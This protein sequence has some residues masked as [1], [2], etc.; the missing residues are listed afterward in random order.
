[1]FYPNRNKYGNRKTVIDGITFDSAKEARR[2]SELK[3]MQRAGLISDLKLQPRFE[4][5]PTF[6]KNGVTHRKIEYVGDFSYTEKGIDI[7]EDVKSDFTR[8]NPVYLIKK[9]LLFFRYDDFVFLET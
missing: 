9:K 2:Y 4:L 6:K 5:L 3:I 1:M 8:K 7:V